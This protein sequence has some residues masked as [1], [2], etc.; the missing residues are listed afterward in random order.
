MDSMVSFMNKTKE[1]FRK[2]SKKQIIEAVLHLSFWAFLCYFF[3]NN[4]FLRPI[5]FNAL[6]KEVICVLF[7]ATMVYLNYFLLIPKLFKKGNHA[8]YWIFAIITIILSGIGEIF[9]VKNNILLCFPTSNT[10]E[11]NASALRSII[12][13]ITMRNVGFFIFFF[14]LKLYR[15]LTKQYLSEKKTISN[16]TNSILICDK[17]TKKPKMVSF[18]EIYYIKHVQDHTFI[19]TITNA[20]YS[21]RRTL[22]EIGNLLPEDRYVWL[23]RSTI[24]MKSQIDYSDKN[25]LFMKKIAGIDESEFPIP[26]RKKAAISAEFGKKK[27]MNE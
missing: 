12:F 2:S 9:L 4:S 24:L 23:N 27:E 5:S 6:Y 13:L 7:I 16:I 3:L 10:M 11:E 8:Y 20:V 21:E 18:D 15:D 22:K 1:Y 14:I 26:E 17:A 25:T 19:Y